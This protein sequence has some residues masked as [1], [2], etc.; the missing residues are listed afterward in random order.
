[1]S[2]LTTTANEMDP[3]QYA[4]SALMTLTIEA[5]YYRSL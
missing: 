1:M 2:R 4:A 3:R 5:A